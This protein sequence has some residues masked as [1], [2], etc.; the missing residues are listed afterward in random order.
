M[1]ISCQRIPQSPDA[2]PLGDAIN[3]WTN[4]TA[5]RSHVAKRV[6]VNFGSQPVTVVLFG[7]R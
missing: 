6:M 7:Q 2:N 5:Y 3:P 4:N 1:R